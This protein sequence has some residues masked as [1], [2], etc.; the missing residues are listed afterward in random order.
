MDVRYLKAD[1]QKQLVDAIEKEG[2]KVPSG[3]QAAELKEASKAGILT[4]EKIESTVAPTKREIDPPLKVTFGEDELRSYFPDKGT[5]VGTV[6]RTM[7]E[8][9]DLRKKALERQAKKEAEK[10]EPVKK[11]A[12]VR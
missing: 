5:T 4:P 6:K 11:M 2:G 12:M 8:A 9:L 10:S 3:T 1:E 7:F